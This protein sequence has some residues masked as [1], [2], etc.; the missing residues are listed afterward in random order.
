MRLKT[1]ELRN[2]LAS[3][4][5]VARR[6]VPLLHALHGHCNGQRDVVEILQ[7]GSLAEEEFDENRNMRSMPGP[8]RQIVDANFT[9]RVKAEV[10]RVW[11]DPLVRIKD[12]ADSRKC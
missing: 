8:R 6:L 12:E 4:E 9:A 3:A 5:A 1:L 2:I 7:L 10:R 11:N